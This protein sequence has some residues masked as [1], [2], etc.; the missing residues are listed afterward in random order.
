MTIKVKVN[1]AWRTVADAKPPK[2]GG[3]FGGGIFI[4]IYDHEY[5]LIA[6][7]MQYHVNKPTAT[8]NI[9]FFSK[10]TL[11]NWSTSAALYTTGASDPNNG[12]VNCQMVDA[13]IT[14]NTRGL[15][16]ANFPAFNYIKNHMNAGTGVN[17]YT[18]WYLP[19]YQELL[20]IFKNSG[21]YPKF[22]NTPIVYLDET[23]GYWSS[24][25]YSSSIAYDTPYY[26][27]LYASRWY[28]YGYGYY[29]EYFKNYW[30]NFYG[31]TS[32]KTKNQGIIP[33]RRV[34][35]V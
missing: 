33:I 21:W 1:N 8:D 31:I 29:Y 14:N 7:E 22:S 25:E 4:G 35:I 18:D 13:Y 16:Y 19:S 2:L 28:W 32:V 17:G 12:Q 24:T 23:I 3:S 34:D 20:F 6:S 10:R 26:H 11:M 30:Y 5:Y 15:T 9:N 27:D